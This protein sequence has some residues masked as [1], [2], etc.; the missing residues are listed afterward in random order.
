MYI[1]GEATLEE[2]AGQDL[3]K[4]FEQL[5]NCLSVASCAKPKGKLSLTPILEREQTGNMHL[6]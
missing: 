1:A 2:S 3:V 5:G 6:S 4:P